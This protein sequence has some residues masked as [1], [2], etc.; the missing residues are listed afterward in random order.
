MKTTKIDRMLFIYALNGVVKCYSDEELREVEARLLDAGWKHTATIDP[1]RWIEAM[2]NGYD[3]P[4]DM[5]DEIQFAPN[6]DEEQNETFCK[7]NYFRYLENKT[8]EY[9]EALNDIADILQLP[10]GV[11]T[12]E[13]VAE[14]LNKNVQLIA[15]KIFYPN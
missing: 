5:L 1:A 2:A 4:S 13:I 14:V 10:T 6:E 15:H 9:G 8:A 12:A 11:T 7:E 3:N